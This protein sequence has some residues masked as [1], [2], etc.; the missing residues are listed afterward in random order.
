MVVAVTGGTGFVGAEVV[1]AHLSRGDDVRVLTRRGSAPALAGARVVRGDLAHGDVP[2]EFLSGVHVLYHCAGEL[3]DERGMHA[4]HVEGTRRLLELAS[5]SVGRWVQL[6]SVGVYGPRR[7]GTITEDTPEAPVGTYERTKAESDALVRTA[8]ARGAL[9]AVILRPSIIFGPGMPN[10]SLFALLSAVDRGLFVFVGPK[11]ASANYVPVENVVEALLLCATL[12]AAAGDVFN[13]S[14]FTT[15]EDFIGT[16]ARALGRRSP[17]LRL[18][19]RPLRA[20]AAVFGVVP[21]WPLSASRVDALSNR[22]VYST[23]HIESKLGYRPPVTVKDAL[24][25]TV[26]RWRGRDHVR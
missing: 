2:K 24:T 15:M 4:L 20:A 18:P 5:G 17:R 16:I 22:A 23:T 1:R 26:A 10:Q 13:L 14:A 8:N 21:R 3:R 11:G 9:D 7:E 25:R 6:S 12:P 19:R